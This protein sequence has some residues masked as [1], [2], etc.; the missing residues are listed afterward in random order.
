LSADLQAGYIEL[1]ALALPNR[2]NQSNSPCGNQ[3]QPGESEGL[4]VEKADER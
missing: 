4:V 1:I 2:C 3:A